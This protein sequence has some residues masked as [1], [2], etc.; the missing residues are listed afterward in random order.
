MYKTQRP[1]HINVPPSALP[2]GRQS[3]EVSQGYDGIKIESLRGRED[4]FNLDENGFQIFQDSGSGV[5]L[6]SALKYE[7]YSNSDVVK[8]RY[9]AAVADFVKER[10]GAEQVFPFTHEACSIDH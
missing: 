8:H 2:P 9:R 4:S 1:Y 7:E 6:G 10:L 5:A 3:N